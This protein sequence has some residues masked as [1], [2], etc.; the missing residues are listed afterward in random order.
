MHMEK[1]FAENTIIACY[2]ET[3][4]YITD[5]KHKQIVTVKEREKSKTSQPDVQ[6]NWN[7]LLFPCSL[8]TDPTYRGKAADR[9]NEIS[10]LA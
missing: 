9:K 1:I 5:T 3:I 8:K 7:F 10:I 6:V 2:K 4:N